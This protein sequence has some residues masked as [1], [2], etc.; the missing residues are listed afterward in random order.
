MAR[1]EGSDGTRE[2]L[3]GGGREWGAAQGRQPAGVRPSRGPYSFD[4]VAANG[5]WVPSCDEHAMYVLPDV[6]GEPG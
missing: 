2:I 3:S 1:T 4:V 6:A 5:L